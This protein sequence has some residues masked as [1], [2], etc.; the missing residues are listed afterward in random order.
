MIQGLITRWA[1]SNYEF[2]LEEKNR[3]YLEHL[4]G[5]VEGPGSF[6]SGSAEEPLGFNSPFLFQVFFESLTFPLLSR[7][8]GH[9][10]SLEERGIAMSRYDNFLQSLNTYLKI[11]SPPVAV[12]MLRKGE[13]P[14]VPA[15]FPLRDYRKRFVLCQP[16][17]SPGTTGRRC[18]WS[19]KTCAAP[20]ASWPWASS[21]RSRI[22]PKDTFA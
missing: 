9:S 6:L 10:F 16:G 12:K 14:P 5:S 3:F 17:R 2:T 11:P 18:A 21:P 19:T 15:K 1:L 20:R 8:I 7:I 13:K 22:S 4:P